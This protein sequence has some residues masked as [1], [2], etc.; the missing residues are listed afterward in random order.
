MGPGPQGTKELGSPGREG[1]APS[2]RPH[3]PT[4][5]AC[6]WHTGPG[7]ACPQV[8]AAERSQP[9]QGQDPAPGP[10]FPHWRRAQCWGS[11]PPLRSPGGCLSRAGSEKAH[12]SP[13]LA[14]RLPPEALTWTFFF[15]NRD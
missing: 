6:G 10:P 2:R 1:G 11:P 7:L 8:P 4:H 13:C 5:R 3:V 12:F 15:G 9:P 14:Q